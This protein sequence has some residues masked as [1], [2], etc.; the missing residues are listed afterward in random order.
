MDF[1]KIMWEGVDWMHI[2]WRMNGIMWTWQWTFGFHKGQ[3]ISWLAEWIISF[4]RNL[5]LEIS[6]LLRL[7][8]YIVGKFTMGVRQKVVVSKVSWVHFAVGSQH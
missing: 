8:L 6:Y 1:W 4:S 2:S 5:L 3:G 7:F